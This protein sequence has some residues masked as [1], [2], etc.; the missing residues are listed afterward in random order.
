VLPA[1]QIRPSGEETSDGFLAA[2][3]AM[4]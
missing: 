2:V 3:L 4:K 1:N